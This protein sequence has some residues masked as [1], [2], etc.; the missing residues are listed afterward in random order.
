[1]KNEGITLYYKDLSK[2]HFYTK[3]QQFK[4]EG[5]WRILKEA[6]DEEL[7]V[8]NYDGLVCLYKDYSFEELGL[9][10]AFLY[11]GANLAY[12]DVNIPLLV[13]L[14]KRELNVQHVIMSDVESLRV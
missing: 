6:G 2:Y 14:S 8:A 10:P 5:E 12:K 11:L 3:S 1:M 13:D 7:G 4:Y 9:K